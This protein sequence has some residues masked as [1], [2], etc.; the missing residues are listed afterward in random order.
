MNR[1]LT[2]PR[3]RS[4]FAQLGFEPAGG[5]PAQFSA[6]MQAE[7]QKWARVI[8]EANVKPE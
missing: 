4:R 8:R 6:A 7:S 3:S 2:D 1:I 5:T